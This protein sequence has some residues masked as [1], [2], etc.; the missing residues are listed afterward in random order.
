LERGLTK[1]AEDLKKDIEISK[2]DILKEL[3]ALYGDLGAID[4]SLS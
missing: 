1:S 2:S 4:S 3:T